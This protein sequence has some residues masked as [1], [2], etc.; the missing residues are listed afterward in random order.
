MRNQGYQNN[1]SAPY[2]AGGGGGAG[3]G[4]YNAGGP[5]NYG[6]PPNMNTGGPR[7]F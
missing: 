3:G 5:G 2:S 6:N 7:R 4:G 1:R